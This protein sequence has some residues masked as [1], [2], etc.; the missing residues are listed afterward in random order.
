MVKTGGAYPQTFELSKLLFAGARLRIAQEKL[1]VTS[2][3]AVYVGLRRSPATARL[4][5]NQ[6]RQGMRGLQIP[7]G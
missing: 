6:P 4:L 1:Q 7:S 2:R 3:R 5:L